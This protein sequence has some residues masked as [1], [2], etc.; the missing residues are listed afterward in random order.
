MPAEL[1]CGASVLESAAP[2]PATVFP[3]VTVVPG[4]GLNGELSSVGASEVHRAERYLEHRICHRLGEDLN[5]QRHVLGAVDRDPHLR[6][7]R[8]RLLGLQDELVGGARLP[9]SRVP[10]VVTSVLGV[11]AASAFSAAS[12]GEVGR[13]VGV[14]MAD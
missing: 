9:R 13:S 2:G 1:G 10:L 7:Q 8:R 4:G 14:G 5:P 6:H 11:I 3:S 12:W